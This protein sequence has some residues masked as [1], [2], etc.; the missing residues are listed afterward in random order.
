MLFF[1]SLTQQIFQAV[2]FHTLLSKDS[3]GFRVC[4]NWYEALKIT[5]FQLSLD[6]AE[7]NKFLKCQQG[8]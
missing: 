8:D 7:K 2:I 5:D 4:H 1:P 6:L 3:F